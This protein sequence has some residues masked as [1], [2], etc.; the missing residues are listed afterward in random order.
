MVK[1]LMIVQHIAL[2]TTCIVLLLVSHTYAF[3]DRPRGVR[4]RG[5][6][7]ASISQ[8]HRARARQAPVHLTTIL[9]FILSFILIMI[10]G[11]ALGY[12]SWIDTLVALRQLF[13]LSL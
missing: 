13:G 12:R 5:T 4:T 3:C 1:V 8:G 7:R 10:L 9:E 2:C 6:A 11:C